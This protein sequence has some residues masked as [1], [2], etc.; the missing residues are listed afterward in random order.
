MVVTLK[1][2]CESR[3]GTGREEGEAVWG[4]KEEEKAVDGDMVKA[5]Y[6]CMKL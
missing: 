3:Q 5:H 1:N 6:V 4:V 2:I